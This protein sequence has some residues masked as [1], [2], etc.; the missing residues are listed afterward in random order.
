MCHG[1]TAADSHNGA[2]TVDKTLPQLRQEDLKPF[3]SGIAAGA[4][5]VMVVETRK[6]TRRRNAM[7][8]TFPTFLR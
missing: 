7:S 5:M 1:S 8:A 2:A 6:K 3:V 4:D